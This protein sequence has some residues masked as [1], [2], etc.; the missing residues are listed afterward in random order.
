MYFS[1]IQNNQFN[2]IYCRAMKKNI[3]KSLTLLL[4]IFTASC[5]DDTEAVIMNDEAAQEFTKKNGTESVWDG[6]IGEER[7]GAYEI[8]ADINVLKQSLED[9]LKIQESPT[10]LTS[11]SIQEKISVNDPS[12]TNYMLIGSDG[13]GI[14]IGVPLTKSVINGFTPVF[15]ASNNL[16]V[17]ISCRGCAEGCN[18]Q[19]MTI[20]GKH[21]PYCNENGCYYNC[22]TIERR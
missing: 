1:L 9:I 6:V 13:N 4:L 10:T 21:Y 19:Y 5:S 14:S 20:H 16:R 22:R 2:L 7:D 17:S 18:L 8:T 15:N 12:V 11:L 3:L